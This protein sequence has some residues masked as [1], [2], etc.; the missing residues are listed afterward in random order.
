MRPTPSPGAGSERFA[1]RTKAALKAEKTV[2]RIGFG[3]QGSGKGHQSRPDAPRIC[4]SERGSPRTTGLREGHDTPPEEDSVPRIAD[5]F[6]PIAPIGLSRS[7]EGTKS[8]EVPSGQR[9]DH[10]ST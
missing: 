4:T 9:P 8:E 1:E 10:A 5:P 3:R 6:R 7:C 2:R